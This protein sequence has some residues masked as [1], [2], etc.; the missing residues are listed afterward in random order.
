M[1]ISN[2]EIVCDASQL[3]QKG[4]MKFQVKVKSQNLSAASTDFRRKPSSCEFFI[5]LYLSE[6]VK[7]GESRGEL[8]NWRII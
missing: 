6:T 1:R 3:I 4:M 7:R 8:K 5:L 2:S